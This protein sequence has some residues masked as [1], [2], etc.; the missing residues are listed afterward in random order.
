[1]LPSF[2]L[3]QK[4]GAQMSDGTM[5]GEEPIDPCIGAIM[6]DGTVYAGIS[7]DSRKTMYVTPTDAPL[8]YNFEEA[9]KYAAHLDAHSYCDWRIPTKDELRVLFK[10]R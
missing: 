5:H 10:N 4:I 3:K 6:P 7:P 9:Q 2:K 1:M 8:T